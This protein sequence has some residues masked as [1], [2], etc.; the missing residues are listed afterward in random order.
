MK[1]LHYI[2]FLFLALG[3]RSTHTSVNSSHSVTDTS[4]K[5]DTVLI[6]KER[7]VTDTIVKFAPMPEESRNIDND[8]SHLE[9]AY[10][11]SNAKINKDGKLEHYMGNKDSV[12]VNIPKGHI[13]DNLHT[14]MASEE[15]KEKI[16]TVIEEKEVVREVRKPLD[17][18]FYP[19]GVLALFITVAYL[20]LRRI[21]II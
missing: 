20:I 9:T 2:C 5:S 13:I 19:L 14:H 10:S 11:W 15:V 21:R 7:I 3:C 8:S 1:N 16:V 17:W 6:Y 12:V 4:H 18:L